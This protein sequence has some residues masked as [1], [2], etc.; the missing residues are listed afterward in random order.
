MLRAIGLS[1]YNIRLMLY[2][3]ILI[4]MVIAILNGTLLGLVFSIGLSGQVEEV[5]ML[6]APL[7]S[8]T[9]VVVIAFVL[10]A[11][12]ST[13]VIRSTSYLTQR[14]VLQTAKI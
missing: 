5:L 9:I 6:K 7:P 14:T 8:L 1:V 2:L 10:L 12:F 3:E 11:I 13:T 4:R